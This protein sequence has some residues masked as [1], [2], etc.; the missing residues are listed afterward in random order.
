[1]P[2]RYGK[3][4]RKIRNRLIFTERFRAGTVLV[5]T[6]PLPGLRRTPWCVLRVSGSSPG[7]NG[8]VSTFVLNSIIKEGPVVLNGSESCGGPQQLLQQW[9]VEDLPT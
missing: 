6:K 8:S 4:Q 9:V 2:L 5:L 3:V 1:M 7:K